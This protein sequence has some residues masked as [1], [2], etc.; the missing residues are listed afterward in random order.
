MHPGELTLLGS[1]AQGPGSTRSTT[2]QP[3]PLLVATGTA[4][5][6]GVVGATTPLAGPLLF[7]TTTNPGQTLDGIFQWTGKGLNWDVFGHGYAGDTST[8][9]PDANVTNNA[10][11]AIELLRVCAI[12]TRPSKKAPSARSAGGGPVSCPIR[13]SWQRPWYSAAVSG[14]EANGA[15]WAHTR[16]RTSGTVAM[17]RLA[18]L[19]SPICGTRI[20]SARSPRTISSPAAC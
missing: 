9:T 20:T 2:R 12:T 13:T 11:A 1:S 15:P 19:V 7:T 16:F 5:G 6:P 17:T 10:V 3:C 18:K 4:A 14:G 8:C